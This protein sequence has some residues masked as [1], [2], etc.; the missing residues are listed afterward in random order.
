MQSSRVYQIWFKAW[1]LAAVGHY[2]LNS[3]FIFE[4][5]YYTLTR[6]QVSICFGPPCS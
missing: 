1:F 5:V 3:S 2:G 4:L 6:N